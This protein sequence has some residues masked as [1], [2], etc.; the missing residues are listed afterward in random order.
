MNKLH[1]C[2]WSAFLRTSVCPEEALVSRSTTCI[3]RQNSLASVRKNPI[4]NYSFLFSKYGINFILI[5]YFYKGVGE[6][7]FLIC[8]KTPKKFLK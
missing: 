1:R 6:C 8:S 3:G 5:E 4:E 7:M 2:S